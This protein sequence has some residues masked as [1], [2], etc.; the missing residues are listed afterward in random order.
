VTALAALGGA[1]ATLGLLLVIIGLRGTAGEQTPSR[2]AGWRLSLAG[3]HRR[4]V[5]LLI[6]LPLVSWALTGWVVAVLFALV[7]AL[8]LPRLLGGRR[9]AGARIERLQALAD[10]TR[11]LGDVLAAGAGIEQAIESSGAGAPQAIST[12]VAT[13][14]ARIRS[15]QP[16]ERAL[17]DFAEEL[18]D[19]TGDLVAGALLLAV[20]RRGRG[21]ARLLAALATS[22]DAEV[23]MRRSVEADRAT[24]RTTARWVMYITVVVCGGLL[25]FDH[26]YVAPFGS[27]AGQVV[28]AII[29]ALLTVSFVWMHRLTDGNARERWLPDEART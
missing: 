3:L 2:R 7:A 22:V 28:L 21:L 4:N 19:P 11:R 5:V 10:W 17:R 26:A 1:T 27:P 16:I 18:D 15:R 25:V 20:D 9:A 8:G 13:L 23:A 14:V 29:G 6:V 24:P 12:E